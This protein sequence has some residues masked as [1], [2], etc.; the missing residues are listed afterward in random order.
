MLRQTRSIEAMFWRA[1]DVVVGLITGAIVA[2]IAGALEAYFITIRFMSFGQ[3]GGPIGSKLGLL[4]I[5]GAVV[6]GIVGL[7]LG[8]L[9]KP[10]ASAR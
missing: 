1:N 6:G 10:R 5:V 4:A 7:F 9:I 3:H 2:V 8:A